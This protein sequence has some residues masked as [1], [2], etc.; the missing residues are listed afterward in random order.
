MDC[1]L[2]GKS[3][4]F[5]TGGK[6]AVAHRNQR[7]RNLA[8]YRAARRAK[9][10]PG[11]CPPRGETRHPQPPHALCVTLPR[12]VD[13]QIGGPFLHLAGH[14]LR[15]G[16]DG[17]DIKKTL[18]ASE[19][20]RPDIRQARKQWRRLQPGLD[21]ASLVFLDESGEKTNMTRAR[22]DGSLVRL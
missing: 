8:D 11:K 16:V 18:R 12:A 15:A 14:P 20:D 17:A 9:S 7:V 1:V 13:L 22:T 19:Q 2:Y 21:P 10:R 3:H 6:I 5:E 4:V